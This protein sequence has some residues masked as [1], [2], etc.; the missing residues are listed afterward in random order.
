MLAVPVRGSA[1]GLVR[2]ASSRRSFVVSDVFA[3]RRPASAQ[4]TVSPHFAR[5]LVPSV[6]LPR[7][8]TRFPRSRSRTLVTMDSSVQAVQQGSEADAASKAS[9][10]GAARTASYVFSHGNGTVVSGKR[11]SLDPLPQALSQ[12]FIEYCQ[13]P[14][15]TKGCVACSETMQPA[16]A[17]RGSL[18][19]SKLA[20]KLAL[21]QLPTVFT[22]L[23]FRRYLYPSPTKK[24]L[25]LLYVSTQ[26]DFEANNNRTFVN[27]LQ[28]SGAEA[29]QVGAANAICSRVSHFLRCAGAGL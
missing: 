27:T 8:P 22:D 3:P 24:G 12:L 6:A 18:R 25:E 11:L 29:G 26:R 7:V 28:L 20:R 17:R 4:L 23:I 5:R 19:V 21:Q 15:F 2:A 14:A 9:C 10:Q 16:C 1:F 13:P